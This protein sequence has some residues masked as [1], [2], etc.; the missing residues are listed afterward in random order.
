MREVIGIVMLV[1]QGLVP[2]VLL[3][4]GSESRSWYAVMY[5]PPWARLPAALA[6]AVVGAALVVSGIRAGRGR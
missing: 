4:L 5:L 3:A 1:P 2:L 6:F